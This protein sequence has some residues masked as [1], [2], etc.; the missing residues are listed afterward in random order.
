[1][2]ERFGVFAGAL[3]EVVG[4]FG[5]V[6]GG[7]L[8]EVMWGDGERLVLTGWAQPALFGVQ[9]GLVRLLESWGVRADVVVGHSVGEVAAAFVAGVLSLGDACR[10]VAV[11][12]GLMQ[13]LSVGGVMVAIGASEERVRG[14]LVAGAEVAAVNGPDAVVVSG[15]ADAVAR[16]AAGFERV[17]PLRVSHAFHSGLMEPMLAEF[18]AA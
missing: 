9:V 13:G 4:G 8:R 16:V 18:G 10:L 12:A 6:V 7:G 15:V 1:M 17:R 14:A 3:D 11:R 2:Y 5:G